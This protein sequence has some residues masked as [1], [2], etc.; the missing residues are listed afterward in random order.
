MLFPCRTAPRC[1]GRVVVVAGYAG[2]VADCILDVAFD[3]RDVLVKTLRAC[4]NEVLETGV[5]LERGVPVRG[6]LCSG[7]CLIRGDG[8]IDADVKSMEKRRD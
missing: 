4:I 7:V 2:V 8:T 6:A 3:C 1:H 5:L